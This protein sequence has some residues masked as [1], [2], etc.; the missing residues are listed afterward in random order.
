MLEQIRKALRITH[1]KL[2]DDIS[3]TI[4]ACKRDLS[5]AGVYWVGDEDPLLIQAVKLYCKWQ[6]D[7]EGKA[8]RY[9]KAY[10]NLKMSLGLCGDYNE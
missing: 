1:T 3:D 4:E 2:D 6:F 8:E 9:E 7:H 10:W 5:L